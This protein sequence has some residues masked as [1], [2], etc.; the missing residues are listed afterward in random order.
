M[1]SAIDEHNFKQ[2]VLED[3]QPVL[4]H[5]WAPWCGL[6]KLVEPMLE[7]LQTDF[8]C[9]LK[10]VSVN[11][12]RNFKL[13]NAYRIQSL[14]TLLLFHNGNL[15]QKLD[16]FQNRENLYSTIKIFL[17]KQANEIQSA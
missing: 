13:A 8:K 2:E 5:F 15:L 16:G 7:T 9:R 12:D 4:V 14:P 10:L 17:A 1:S 6:C 3:C 11:A